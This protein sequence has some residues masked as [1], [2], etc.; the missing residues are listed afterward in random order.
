MN[1]L[2]S[3]PALLDPFPSNTWTHYYVP[4][5]SVS[6]LDY[7]LPPKDLKV[8]STEIIRKGLTT[9]CKQYNG[10]RYPTVG[11]EHT[12]TSD[13]CPTSVTLDLSID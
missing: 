11:P 12:E 10:H 6:R 8:T 9:K 7:I 5:K 1:A 4:E 13:H 2:L 3:S